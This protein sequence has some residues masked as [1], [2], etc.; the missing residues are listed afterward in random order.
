MENGTEPSQGD[1]KDPSAFLADIIGNPVTV[2]LNSGVVYKGKL[3]VVSNSGAQISKQPERSS[4]SCGRGTSVC[5]RLHEHLFGGLQR[6]RRWKD[7]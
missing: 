2:K 5:R 4:I 3:L 1:G 6:G 7:Y